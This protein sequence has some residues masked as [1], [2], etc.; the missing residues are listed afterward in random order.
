MRRAFS[1]HYDDHNVCVD[2]NAANRFGLGSRRLGPKRFGSGSYRRIDRLTSFDSVSDTGG[3]SVLRTFSGMVS[4]C[5]RIANACE[6]A[7][8]DR[9]DFTLK[10]TAGAAAWRGLSIN[11]ACEA[12]VSVE[13]GA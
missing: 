5:A 12:G 11:R 1:S 7:G 8:S 9:S 10:V 6:R 4:T 13:P 3:L 2:G